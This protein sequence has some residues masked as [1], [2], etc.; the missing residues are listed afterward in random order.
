[1]KAGAKT[2]V[3]IA[4]AHLWPWTRKSLLPEYQGVG[5][6]QEI[7]QEGQQALTSYY[8][9]KGYFDVNVTSDMSKSDDTRTVVYHVTKGKKHNLT[10]VRLTGESQLKAAD[11]EPHLAVHKQHLFSHGEFS[12]QLVRTSVKNLT[13]ITSRK[14]SAACRSLPQSFIRWQRPGRLSR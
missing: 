12:D 13:A 9:K 2:H 11:L 4:G 6:N 10:A 8:Q 1:M 7:V 3:E 5:V 14:D